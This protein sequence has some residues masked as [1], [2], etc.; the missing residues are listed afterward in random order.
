M[1]NKEEN[2]TLILYEIKGRSQ[3]TRNLTMES[4]YSLTQG[5]NL[6]A[7]VGFIVLVLRH[8]QIGITDTEVAA[9]L[10]GAI[11]AIGIIISWIGRYKKGDL[12]LSGFRK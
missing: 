9:L 11:T 10:G 5:G 6:T 1:E 2:K 4:K 7:I 12:F 8:Y 3:L